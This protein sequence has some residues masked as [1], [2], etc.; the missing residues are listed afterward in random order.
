M[1]QKFCRARNLK[2]NPLT[3]T[4]RRNRIIW[5]ITALFFILACNIGRTAPPGQPDLYATLQASTPDAAESPVATAA[6]Q[7]GA[8]PIFN[9]FTPIPPP[10]ISSANVGSKSPSSI[11]APSATDAAESPVATAADQ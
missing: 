5:I 9:A 6:D 1:A 7:S 4:L 8:P 10:T 11:P 3:S 2:L